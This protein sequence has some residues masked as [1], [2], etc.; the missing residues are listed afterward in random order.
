MKGCSVSVTLIV[1][2]LAVLASSTTSSEND[3]P[4][5]NLY[6][7]KTY[8]V[9][10]SMPIQS[11]T[12]STNYPWLPHNVDP[13]NNP[14][15]PE[16]EGMPIQPLGNKQE[17]YD[18][19]I[20]G[21]RDFYGKK[22]HSCDSTEMDR[23]AM[24]LRQPASMR[25]FTEMGFAKIKAPAEVFALIKAFWDKNRDNMEDERWARGNTYTN[26]WLSNTG[27]V[28]VENTKLSGGGMALKQQI[29]DTA[30]DV[31][32]NWTGQ[33]LIPTSLYGIRVYK[34]HSVLAT[35]VDRLPLVSSAIINVDQDVDEDWPIEVYGHDGNAYNITMEPGDMVL[36]ESHSILHGRP[37]PLVGRFYANIFIHF[38]PSGIPLPGR[39]DPRIHDPP[40]DTKRELKTD[41][42]TD[43]ERDPDFDEDFDEEPAED[44][45]EESQPEIP[46]YIMPGSDE[47]KSWLRKNPNG[48]EKNDVTDFGTGST[49]A[50]RAAMSGDVTTLRNIASSS[51]KGSLYSRDVNGWQPIHEGARGGHLSIVELLVKSGANVNTRANNGKGPTPLY[52][53]RT[54]HGEEH[55]V[56]T[57]LKSLNALDLGPEL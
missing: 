9:D 20:Q 53:A 54:T 36:Y 16:Y 17:F 19:M 46:V 42:D 56:V 21:C 22:G 2:S 45:Q 51:K 44:E 15:P 11:A 55:S 6:G 12:V 24:S 39:E 7:Q 8:G 41:T 1:A 38:E 5:V 32:Q 27:M 43:T 13:E 29:W 25:N 48:W 4:R 47:A 35:H 3:E 23:V 49:P 37:F 50:H 40:L 57:Y 26:H 10:I 14:T 31:L 52:L 33:E 30:R 18:N 28:S 34:E